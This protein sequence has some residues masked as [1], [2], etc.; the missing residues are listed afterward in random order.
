MF[1]I[2]RWKRNRIVSRISSKISSSVIL[3]ALV[4]A[5]AL[6][7][8][9]L[10]DAKTITA[11]MHSDLRVIDPGITTAYI[12]RDH[13]YM[14]YDTLFALDHEYHPHPQM[15]ESWTSSDDGLIWEFKLRDKLAF[16][17]GQKVRAADVVASLKRWGSGTTPMARRCSPPRRRSRRSTTRGSASR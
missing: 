6:V 3:P 14:V 17:D 13:G 1:H 15:V 9:S 16:H 10:A 7:A 11:V 12:T 8:P 5:A 4:L 2:A